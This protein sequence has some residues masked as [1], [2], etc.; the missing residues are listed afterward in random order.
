MNNLVDYVTNMVRSH[1]HTRTHGQHTQTHAHEHTQTHAH[2]LSLRRP[3]AC[4]YSI[5][6]CRPFQDRAGVICRQGLGSWRQSFRSNISPG[7]RS[8]FGNRSSCS[9]RDASQA[10]ENSDQT[11]PE[12]QQ[13]GNQSRSRSP[14]LI[15][16]ARPLADPPLWHSRCSCKRRR[17]N[18]HISTYKRVWEVK[19]IVARFPTFLVSFQSTFSLP[20]SLFL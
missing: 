9:R 12:R 15:C 3:S 18:G 19:L 17:P 1:T 20:I 10:H 6:T 7:F 13:D 11:V 4:I 16:S 8:D 5:R 2:S 14:P